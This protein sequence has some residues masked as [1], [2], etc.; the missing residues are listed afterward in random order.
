MPF[1][2]TLVHVATGSVGLVVYFLAGFGPF[3][4]WL[5]LGLLVLIPLDVRHDRERKRARE[6]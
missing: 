3:L 2:L 4:V 1:W 6:S 5:V